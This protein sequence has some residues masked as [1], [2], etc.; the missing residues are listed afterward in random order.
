[1]VSDQKSLGEL[2]VT[3]VIAHRGSGV[4]PFENTLRGMEMAITWGA[5]GIECDIQL[6]HDRELVVFHDHSLDRMTNGSGLLAEHSLEE[7]KALRVG[8]GEQIPTL[9]ELLGFLKPHPQFLINL[10]VKVQEIE[11]KI[12]NEIQSH[13]LLDRVLISSLI[14]QV[15]KKVRELNANIRTGWIYEYK[16]E[17]PV[18]EALNLECNA[19]HPRLDL[20]TAQLRQASREQGLMLNPWSINS[21]KDMRR[22]IE[23]DVD[24]II[25]DE[26]SQLLRVLGRREG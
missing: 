16:Y 4:G 23:L 3:K 8:E 10:D 24:W 14:T 20:V 25:T 22:F 19:L 13:H 26:P 17:D 12:L 21:D 1:L 11:T 7:L 18:T 9:A 15:L 6:S 5:D 2:T